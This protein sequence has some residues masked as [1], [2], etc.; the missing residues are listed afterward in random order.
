MRRHTSRE[1]GASYP[2][3]IR[4]PQKRDVDAITCHD[5]DAFDLLQNLYMF[6]QKA[7]YLHPI[8]W[9]SF[10]V[11]NILQEFKDGLWNAIKITA[12]VNQVNFGSKSYQSSGRR[13]WNANI[14]YKRLKII[15]K[16]H[17]FKTTIFFFRVLSHP[18]IMTKFVVEDL[19]L[20]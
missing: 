17:V 11:L 20:F 4:S 14:Q 6:W 2:A 5:S 19:V 3:P 12:C 18:N 13:M 8:T 7:N 9:T 1:A 16:R 10:V 15:T